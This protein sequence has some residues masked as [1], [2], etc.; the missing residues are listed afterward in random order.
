MVAE[1]RVVSAIAFSLPLLACGWHLS[2]LVY[3]LFKLDLVLYVDYIFFDLILAWWWTTYFATWT[4][5]SWWWWPAEALVFPGLRA[6][7][8]DLLSRDDRGEEDR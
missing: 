8:P 1:H 4:S 6:L 7:R 2:R 3:F 5:T